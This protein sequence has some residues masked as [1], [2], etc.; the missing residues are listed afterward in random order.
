M[1]GIGNEEIQ[2]QLQALLREALEGADPDVPGTYFTDRGKSLLETLEPLTAEEASQPIGGTSIA[3]HVKHVAFG[4]EVSTAW[5][6]GNRTRAD[7]KESWQVSRVDDAEWSALKQDLQQAG[8]RFGRAVRE[9]TFDDALA[10]G[11]SL[12]TI[13]HV[14][15]HLG[16]IRQKLLLLD[17]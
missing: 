9:H 8:S 2:A 6:A 11:V 13:A 16:A 10:F 17:R 12:G 3:A 7:W 14:A 15:A 5:V 1:A 4:M